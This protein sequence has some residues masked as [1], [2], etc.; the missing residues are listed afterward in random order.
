M[1][2]ISS[3]LLFLLVSITV[4]A[5][6]KEVTPSRNIH[7][8]ND[9]GR[10]LEMESS[11]HYW[12]EGPLSLNMFSVRK[13][14]YPMILDLEYGIHWDIERFKIG[15]TTISAPTTRTLMNPFS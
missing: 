8:V 11:I 9:L 10:G 5:Q 4:L 6:D 7:V 15:N 1:K 2:K 12:D 3:L 14:K 13:D